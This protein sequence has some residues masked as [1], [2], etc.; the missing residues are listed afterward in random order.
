MHSAPVPW[1]LLPVKSFLEGKQRLAP[2]L[3]DSERIQLNKSFFSHMLRIARAYPG[4]ER[5]AIVSDADDAIQAAMSHGAHIIR[6]ARP[7]LNQALTAGRLFLERKDV[8][9]ILVLP[10]DLPFVRVQEL[11]SISSLGSKHSVVIAPDK[12]GTG[13]NALFLDSNVPLKFQFGANSFCLHRA[14][15]IRCGRQPYLFNS[16]RISLD[17]DEPGDLSRF[18]TYASRVDRSSPFRPYRRSA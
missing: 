7:G 12:T 15:S 17:I 13:T 6:C 4:L 11:V 5:T 8:A 1:L 16:E 9:S 14:E 10:V 3:N 18:E 2:V